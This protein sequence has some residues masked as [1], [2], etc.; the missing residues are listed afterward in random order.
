MTPTLIGRI[1]T[2]I[3]LLATVGLVW[4]I[5]VVPILPKFGASIGDV[6]VATL[7]ALLVVTVVG[8]GWEL[9]YHFIQQYRWE[10]DWPIVFSL[11]LGIPEG[12]LTFAIL[13]AILDPPPSAVT[14][15]LHFFTTW[16][17]VWLVANGP[18][19]VVFLRWKFK[20]GRII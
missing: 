15:I 17:L 16:I 4:T 13:R 7:L 6:Y 11:V 18:V 8:F 9:L 1:Q 10:K 3:A 2:R 12:V 5:L 19:R 14:F 20:G